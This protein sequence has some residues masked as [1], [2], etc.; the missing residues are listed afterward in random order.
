MKGDFSMQ[1]VRTLFRLDLKSRF[2]SVQKIGLS[3]RM[4]Q[5]CGYVFFV[6][7][8]ALLI[9]GIYFL[10][11]M[12]VKESGLRLEFL[13]IISTATILIATAVATSTIVKNLYQNGDNE[14]LL[15]FPVSG[16]EI[17]LSKSIYC[18]LHNLVVCVLL[19]LPFYL[20][21]GIVTKAP[22][23]D[24]FAYLA[25]MLISTLI[26]FFVA[27]IIAVPVMKIMNVVKNQFLLVLIFTI[28]AICGVFVLYL[29]SLS[30]VLE[31]LK[32]SEQDI[33]SPVVIEYIKAFANNAYPFKWYAELI[34]GKVYGGLNGGQ[35]ALR[36]LYIF[37]LN[38]VLGVLAYFVTTRQYYKTILYGI[39][40]QKTSFTKKIKDKQHSVPV[41]LFRREFYLILRSFNYSFQYFAMACAA[42][43]M[44]FFCNRLA[45]TM[46]TESVGAGIMPGLTL[47]VVVIFVAIIVSFAST[48]ISREGE[49]FY[50][51]KIIPVSYTTQVLVKFFLYSIVAAISVALCCMVSGIYYTSEAGGKLLT[52][53]D[54]GAI[55]GISLITVI[56]LTCLSMIADIKSPT[57]NVSGDGEMVSANK[58]LAIALVVGIVVAAVYGIFGMVFSFMPLVIGDWV[59]I[60]TGNMAQIYGV[61]SVFSVLLLI[62]SVLGLFINLNKRYHKLIP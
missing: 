36:C 8:Y 49:S 53:L 6:A 52:A 3:K 46:G 56:S 43:V 1:S 2:G 47:M 51:T 37:L 57:F 20:T 24:Y 41:A 9:V 35:M 60:E 14:L 22:A 10:T 19:M 44:V 21:F 50:H 40:T 27:N 59:V 62:G 54:V 25:I 61:L 16:K 15:R 45:C 26:P 28:I 12:F 13:V 32:N 55:F 11:S 39:E 34:N 18:F 29:T 17:L 31:F 23:G 58:N 7:I 4:M 5:I 38:A 33:F 42:P 48:C 30:N